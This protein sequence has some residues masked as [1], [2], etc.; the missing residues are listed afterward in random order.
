MSTETLYVVMRAIT[1]QAVEIGAHPLSAP[2]GGPQR[3]IPVFDTQ[4]QAISWAEDG[5]VIAPIHAL[6]L[7]LPSREESTQG[8]SDV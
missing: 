7:P 8:E 1:W 6:A 2:P 4:E 5:D 3:F